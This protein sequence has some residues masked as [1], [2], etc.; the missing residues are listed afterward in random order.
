MSKDFDQAVNELMESGVLL[1]LSGDG[2]S[3]FIDVKFNE[4][5][6]LENVLE[7]INKLEKYKPSK[8]RFY[9]EVGTLLDFEFGGFTKEQI[10]GLRK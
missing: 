8:F 5:K 1:R 10:D 3:D 9:Y 4:H 7:A 2:R 6:S